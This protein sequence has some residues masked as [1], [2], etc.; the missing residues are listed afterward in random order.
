MPIKPENRSR[1]PKD[2]PLIRLEVLDR[3]GH[4]CEFDGCG[5]K[6]GELGLRDLQGRWWPWNAFANGLVDADAE[7]E[8]PGKEQRKAYK[9]VLT[10]AHLDHNP[11]NNGVTGDRPNLRA[12]CQYHHLNHDRP[13]HL[14]NSRK[15]RNEKKGQLS[16]L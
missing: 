9:I 4:R 2:W 6:N 12:W 14:E 10:I 8:K 11:E 3:A 1:Y 7:F 13:H 15:T 5:V 16:L